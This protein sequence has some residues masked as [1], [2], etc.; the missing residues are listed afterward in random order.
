MPKDLNKKINLKKISKKWQQKWKN[1]YCFKWN[2][3]L[4][5][6]ENF[7]IDTPPP[8]VS[9][10]LHMGH[11]FSY[12]QID[13]IARYQ[14][15]KGKNVYF[16]IGFDDNGLPT[17]RLV[18]K[19]K[20]IK[21]STINKKLFN[22][23]CKSV[24][25]KLE[26]IYSTLFKNLG[27]SFDWKY[28]Y[29]TINE[30]S[31][32]ISQMSFLDLYNRNLIERKYNPCFW[33]VK[34]QTVISQAEIVDINRNGTMYDIK[35]SLN[36]LNYIIISTTRPEMLSSC[37]AIFFNPN[38]CRYKLLKNEFATIPIF[39]KKI[40]IL[41]DQNIDIKMGTGLVMCCTFGSAQDVIWWKK[42]NLNTILSI[43]PYGK[44]QNSS[45]LNNFKIIDARKIIVKKLANKIIKERNVKQTIK[46]AERSGMILEIILTS[47]WYIKILNIKN[48]FQKI[49]E[50]INWRPAF[51]KEKFDNWINGLN[52]DWCISRQRY[53]GIPIP[54]W[55]SLKK[56]ER[57]KII[58]PKKQDLPIDPIKDLPSGYKRNQVKAET[59]IMDTW[60]TSSLTPQINNLNLNKTFAIIGNKKIFPF[61]LRPQAHE[62]IRTWTFYTIVKSF[63]HNKTLPW[64]NVM[65]SGWCKAKNKTKMSKSKDNLINPV[66]LLEQYG[67]DILRYWSSNSKLG[68]DVIFKEESFKN[69]QKLI[70]KL[71]N[72]S[73]FYISHI[74]NTI[75]NNLNIFQEDLPKLIYGFDLWVISHLN[76]SIIKMTKLFENYEYHDARE[77]IENFFWKIFCDNYL[78]II[79]G[80]IYNNNIKN[81]KSAI[82][83]LGHIIK[84]ILILFN[85]FIPHITEE[86]N[87]LI[88]SDKEFLCKKGAWPITNYYNKN[89]IAIGNKII[90][91]LNLVRK[92][93][94]NKN[95]SLNSKIDNLIC[96]G[97]SIPNIFMNDFKNASKCK[98]ITT[99]ANKKNRYDIIS[100]CKNLKIIVT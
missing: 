80:R 95:I 9:G 55:F 85:P 56:G 39:N 66:K 59:N 75:D 31:I 19:L 17:E 49:G 44:M 21:P 98:K 87:F 12:T 47:Q 54:I 96:I 94:T 2:T 40:K 84:T 34:D 24:T 58:T 68:N 100:E 90:I 67:P 82:L 81:R 16:T 29:Q 42:Y 3:S 48:K 46:I 10:I 71:Y 78:E 14:R 13:F 41:T 92:Y 93:K 91:L 53:F 28:E 86:L 7:S 57:G 23:L 33:D 6:S 1:K 11:V 5:R 79:K 27:I 45:F 37:V 43:N 73:K 51:M 61:D 32:M 64:Y 25:S 22:K 8:T 70:N 52:Q 18:E 74:K 97:T 50:N 62:I 20:K 89:I 60:A 63:Y 83:T 77:C 35:F 88:F 72:A 30:K 76:K 69:G 26:S 15:L 38:D 99:K 4:K 36:N 65:I